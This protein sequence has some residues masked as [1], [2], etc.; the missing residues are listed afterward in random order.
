MKECFTCANKVSLELNKEI[1]R[2]L[3]DAGLKL[4]F[5]PDMIFYCNITGRPIKQA[6]PAC[7]NYQGDELRENIRKN[8]SDWARKERQNLN[9]TDRQ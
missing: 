1:K 3:R 8:L 9:K 5:V 6:D 7:E 2:G 4:M